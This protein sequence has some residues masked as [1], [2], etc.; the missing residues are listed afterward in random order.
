M[1][2]LKLSNT[3]EP[4]YDVEMDT[5]G[6]IYYYNKEGQLHNLKGPAI[7]YPDDFKVY[8][9][10]GKVNRLNGPAVLGPNGYQAYYINDKLHRTDGPAKI[11]PDGRVE[12]WVKGKHLSKEEFDK[13]IRNNND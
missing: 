7:E 10:N 5:L 4:F 11:Y 2:N 1:V 12:Y 8:Y 9:V 3:E 6:T 13:L